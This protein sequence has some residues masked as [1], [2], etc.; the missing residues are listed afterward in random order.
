MTEKTRFFKE[1]SEEIHEKC[2][3]VMSYK[4]L[5]KGEILFEEGSK[6]TEFFIVLEGQVAVCKNEEIFNEE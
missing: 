5:Q 3:K 6:A 2:C 1:R 4:F